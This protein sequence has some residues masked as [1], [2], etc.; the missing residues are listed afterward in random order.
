MIFYKVVPEDHVHEYELTK[1]L[2]APTC[3]TAG[4]GVYTCACGNAEEE[5]REIPAS[6]EYHNW[7]KLDLADQAIEGVTVYKCSICE[8]IKTEKD[9]QQ[10][11]HEHNYVEFDREEAEIPCIEE[12]VIYK[13]C[14]VC[15]DVIE[16]VIPMS[17][18]ESTTP[19]GQGRITSGVVSCSTGNAQDGEEEVTCKNCGRL[20]T[21][22]VSAHKYVKTA[23]VAAT[24][25][26]E[27]STT[28]KCSVCGDTK[29]ESIDKID[30]D[31]KLVSSTEATCTAT[32]L[33]LYVCT[34][35]AG[36]KS[37]VKKMVDHTKPA[38]N[39][40]K[41]YAVKDPKTGKYGDIE[42]LNGKPEVASCKGDLIE[43][44]TC[45]KCETEIIEV[46][47]K[48]LDHMVDSSVEVKE[49]YIKVSVDVAGNETYEKQNG[50]YVVEEEGKVACEHSKVKVYTCLHCG[51]EVLVELQE[52]TSHNP[53]SGS[54]VEYGAT[55]TN[56]SYKTY[57]CTLCNQK[58]TENTSKEGLGHS[59]EY[60]K[61]T[62][63]TD[64]KVKCIRCPEELTSKSTGDDKTK[65]EEI[66]KEAGLT[67][68]DGKYVLPTATGHKIIKNNAD[69]TAGY[70]ANES[71][72]IEGAAIEVKE[73]ESVP[74]DTTTYESN[75]NAELDAELEDRMKK[76]DIEIKDNVV[77]ITQK[78]G[79]AFSNGGDNHNKN[80]I[81]IMLNVGIKAKDLKRSC[82][83]SIEGAK[84]RR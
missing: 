11:S 63:T 35:C 40:K 62:C 54:T 53:L 32:G 81:G 74:A 28:Y 65:F 60:V 3:Q 44:Y 4:E 78:S 7:Q 9:E 16:E 77:T 31:Y 56:P 71:K 26:A 8:E 38:G 68:T 12:G 69:N 34:N 70:C 10:T 51:E 59:Y 1:V 37:T 46:I 47:A 18:H 55:C 22:K 5:I 79:Q 52:H 72:W 36:T 13:E 6:D 19:E 76:V 80:A 15:G 75:S 57:T 14:T 21:R 49:G 82:T 83:T 64:A 27:G 33:E 39:V 45:E 24:C 2:I 43:K 20:F 66:C 29:V 25:T 48:Q 50:K 42:E 23:E 84:Y 61:E 17:E 73:E 67:L 30:H 41:G 58:I